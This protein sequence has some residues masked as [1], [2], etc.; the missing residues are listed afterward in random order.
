MSIV[1]FWRKFFKNVF[2]CCAFVIL[3]FLALV[4]NLR[5]TRLADIVVMP[6]LLS[7]AIVH[8]VE[9][10]RIALQAFSFNGSHRYV[11]FL[12]QF[13]SA[14]RMD[15][16]Q[17]ANHFKQTFILVCLRDCLSVQ[18]P[19]D[20]ENW[21][22][23]VFSFDLT[24][25]NVDGHAFSW[26]SFNTACLDIWGPLQLLEQCTSPRSINYTYEMKIYT[27]NFKLGTLK[28]VGRWWNALFRRLF[29]SFWRCSYRYS[30]S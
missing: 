14:E 16:R 8:R 17:N 23:I 29:T 11:S 2:F 3:H 1:Q 12:F 13:S 15:S 6:V 27:L 25:D 22:C 28:H 21:T 5:P 18:L 30:E 20:I 10:M 26:F 7:C 4:S 9:I 19:I 24:T